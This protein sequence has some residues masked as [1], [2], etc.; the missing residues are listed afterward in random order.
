MPGQRIAELRTDLTVGG[1]TAWI[2]VRGAGD[3]ARTK[4]SPQTL[5]QRASLRSCYFLYTHAYRYFEVNVNYFR[6]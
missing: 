5:K 1:D 2:I 3:Q 4:P 6:R